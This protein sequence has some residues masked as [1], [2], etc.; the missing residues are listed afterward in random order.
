MTKEPFDKL[1][2]A[3]FDL[4]GLESIKHAAHI[5]YKLM[6][7]DSVVMVHVDFPKRFMEIEY[8]EPGKNTETI[9]ETMKPVRATLKSRDIIDY[10]D[11]VDK[12]YHKG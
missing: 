3:E 5:Q 7:L 12:G 9:L 8:N 2:K 10:S 6:L 4:K 1:M 11:L